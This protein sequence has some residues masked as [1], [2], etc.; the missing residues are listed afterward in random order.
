MAEADLPGLGPA[1]LVPH[2]TPGLKL[3]E[4]KLAPEAG[5]VLSRVD[6]RTSLGDI[7]LL[8]P[9]DR[10]TTATLLRELAECGAIEVPGAQISRRSATPPRAAGRPPT[11][12]PTQTP[13]GID[14]SAEQLRRIDAYHGSLATRDAYALL[15]I[16]RDADKREVKRA[17]FRLSKEFHPDRFYG[18]KIGPYADKL[19]AIFQA[20]KAAFELLSDD[21]RRAAY[22]DSK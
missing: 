14:L 21:Q 5:F 19:N 8:V 17:Y 2:L 18:Q 10:Q 15:E 12:T 6:G 9:F 22:D 4:L 13:Q 3:N 1:A 16:A 11:P 7:C 20:V